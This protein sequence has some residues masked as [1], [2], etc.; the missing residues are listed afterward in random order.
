MNVLLLHGA[1][2]AKTQFTPL[3][4]RLQDFKCHTLDFEGHGKSELRSKS[5][6]IENFAEQCAEVIQSIAQEPM[7]IIGYSMGGY[8]AL[9]LAT[10]KPELVHS[11][12]TLGTKFAWSSA[13]SEKE[14]AMLDANMIR[15]KVPAYANELERRHTAYGWENVLAYTADMMLDLGNNPRLNSDILSKVKCPVRLGVGDRDSMVSITETMEVYK[16]IPD[17]E[18]YVLPRTKHPLEQVPL[19]RFEWI[20]RDWLK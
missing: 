18:L 12:I 9:W 19:D 13:T 14:V 4:E 15:Q 3:V 6:R 5:F 16:Q 8:V 2:G 7:R 11:I 1:L 20:I 17:A 10:H